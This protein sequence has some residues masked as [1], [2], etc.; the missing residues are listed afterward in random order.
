MKKRIAA[1]LALLLLASGIAACK[2]KPSGTDESGTGGGDDTVFAPA[3]GT[4]EAA[5]TSPAA[6]DPDGASETLPETDTRAGEETGTASAPA[7]TDT[8]TEPAHIRVPAGEPADLTPI[9]RGESAGYDMQYNFAGASLNALRADANLRFS[10]SGDMTAGEQGLTVPADRWAAVG[11]AR[12]MNAP[13][14]VT[15]RVGAANPT[16]AAKVTSAVMLGLRCTDAGHIYT[17]S[18]LWIIVRDKAVFA[19]LG[20]DTTPVQLAVNLPAGLDAGVSLRAEDD[21]SVLRVFVEE[22]AVATA[23]F[24]DT[25]VR[26]FNAAGTEVA[27]AG[28]NRIAHGAN[29]GYTR[30]LSHNTN[31]CLSALS[32][33]SKV[34]ASYATTAGTVALKA[35]RDYLFRDKVQYS[36]ALPTVRVDGHY[37]ADAQALATLFGFSYSFNGNTAT[38]SRR[39]LTLTF[40]AGEDSVG[41]NGVASPFP[42]VVRRGN[43]LLLC[44][45]WL[46][47]MLGY[48]A[49][50][51]EDTLYIFPDAAQDAERLTAVMDERYRLYETTVYDR[52]TPDFDKTGVGKYT[53]TDPAA[54]LVGIAYTAGHTAAKS[55]G[56]AARPLLGAYTSDDREIIYRHGVWLAA[57]GVDFVYVDWSRNTL[58]DPDIAGDKRSEYRT[59]EETTDLL[60]EIWSSIPG[61]PRICI[62]LGPGTTGQMGIAG[63]S[64]Q[65]KADQ[66]YRAYAEKYPDLYFCYEGKPLL[67]CYGGTPA[68]LG[69]NPDWKDD[70]FTV[71]WMTDYAGV[72]TALIEPADLTAPVYWTRRDR[73]AQVLSV[74]GRLAEAVSCPPHGAGRARRATPP[75]LPP[76]ALSPARRFAGS[77]HVPTRWAPVSRWSARGTSGLPRP[78]AS[79][80]TWSR[81]MPRAPSAMTCSVS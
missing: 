12:S 61:A 16:G 29:L 37:L 77:S 54:R 40:R 76:A 42:T 4:G 63:G 46:A 32:A 15:A 3:T 49:L 7:E 2:G 65:R 27:S 53:A 11:F 57:A 56:S 73:D 55:W 80:L 48:T 71:R 13:C 41:V 14:T 78:S 68:R 19:C 1:A 58:Y 43:G 74:R 28:L 51:G 31:G 47:P 39:L 70:R 81:P 52:T 25:A 60:F 24:S 59:I 36:A 44:A 45:D 8:E 6:T 21:G 69:T 66:V 5:T 79:P 64:H 30:I 34:S 20:G 67:L 22:T 18:G 35:E 9:L 33:V 62:L 17:D 23:R 50:C 75:M 72:Q 10:Q 26:L 38:L